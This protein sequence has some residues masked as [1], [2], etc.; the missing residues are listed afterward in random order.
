M[1][2]DTGSPA[3]A[4]TGIYAPVATNSSSGVNTPRANNPVDYAAANGTWDPSLNSGYGGY[5]LNAGVPSY[6]DFVNGS[7]STGSGTSTNTGTPGTAATPAYTGADSGSLLRNFSQSDLNADPVYQNGLQFGLDQ[8]TGAINARA[9]QMG[10]YDS[11]A[12]LKALTRYANDYG[13]TKANEAYNRYN[14]NNNNIYNRLAGV[15]GTGQTA[16]NQVD[17]AALNT[18]NNISNNIT[19]AGNATAAGIVGGA[20]AWG[21]AVQGGINAYG[22][23]QNNQTLQQ[24]LNKGYGSNTYDSSLTG[25]G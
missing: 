7:S 5:T 24:L 10:N 11:G 16:T 17:S 15:S 25:P 20:N 14:T 8:G 4:G 22:N 19:G 9:T 23:Y 13:S 6:A 1:G 21:G 12:T 3:V 2:L 18:G